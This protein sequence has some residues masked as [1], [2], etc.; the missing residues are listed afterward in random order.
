MPFTTPFVAG[1]D[2][3][4]TIKDE[5]SAAIGK[6][7]GR[8]RISVTDLINPRQAFFQRTHAEIRPSP[9][10]LQLMLSGTGF[11]DVLGR[12][13]STEEFVE[14]FVEFEGVVGKID[15]YEDIPTELKTTGFIPDDLLAERG[16]YIDQLGMYCVMTG[17]DHGRLLVYK[18]AMYGRPPALR[19]FDCHYR[20][21]RAI[22]REMTRR[23]DLLGD[24]LE[25]NDPSGLPRCE[26]LRIGCDYSAICGCQALAPAERVVPAQAVALEENEAL[27]RA[28]GAQVAKGPP[29][30]VG[31]RLNDL[32]FPRKAAFEHRAPEPAED[33][34]EVTDAAIEERL[35]DF[36]RKG[37]WGALNEALRFGVPGA[38][39]RQ[40][41]E[42][43]SVKGWVGSFK[44][45]PTLL[46][47][48]KWR[49]MVDRKQLPER[50]PHY[51]D[52]LAFECALTRQERG[53]IIVYYEAIAGDKFMV[54]D[55]WFRDL[56][57]IRAEADRRLSLLEAGAA[58]DRL[59]PCPA[60]MAKFCDYAPR[61]GCA[62]AGLA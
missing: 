56:A 23:R 48:T 24:A 13:V 38:F 51:F 1:I 9:E 41:V 20:N 40:L 18:R 49:D 4:R 17:V 42:L 29:A 37:F 22:V 19:A 52:R 32:V 50:F 60:W 27:A 21:P 45:A 11:H 34:D 62:D 59:P 46:R 33:A 31:F 10:R 55:I 25:T 36:E 54:Y 5:L 2:A 43:R 30:T 44:G 6:Q 26:W 15:I 28:I 8:R 57:A 47:S 3:N 35:A 12:A 7:R 58:P 16:S 39:T 14:Q 61:C 53:R